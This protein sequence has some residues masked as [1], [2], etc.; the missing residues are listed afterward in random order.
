MNC[1]VDLFGRCLRCGYRVECS[2]G[3]FRCPG[4]VKPP[5]LFPDTVVVP[6]TTSTP[7]PLPQGTIGNDLTL[8][9]T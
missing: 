9:N 8:F 7:L 5:V 4:E 2:G 3:C 1:G 6:I